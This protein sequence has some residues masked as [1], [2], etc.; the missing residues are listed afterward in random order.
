MKTV[1][2]VP[3]FQEDK[4]SRNYAATLLAIE[5]RGYT[6]EFVSIK[7]RYTTQRDWIEQL[8]NVCSRYDPANTV[9]AGFSFG[10]VI[11][12]CAAADYQP[13]EVWLFSLSPLFV[14]YAQF[15]SSSDKH[16]IGKRRLRIAGETSLIK[17]ISTA[18]YPMKIF[19][20]EK[21]LLRW[22][23]MANVYHDVTRSKRANGIVIERIGHDVTA[24]EYVAAIEST[25]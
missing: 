18:N 8:N 12:L 13:S 24:K 1:L 4:A 23:E 7:W 2:F 9:L 15:W 20:G 6:V 25:I 3:G 16:V 22:P 19:V 5:Q 10:A 17:L 21:E 14:E 11:A